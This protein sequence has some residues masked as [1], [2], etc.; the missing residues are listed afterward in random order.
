MNEIMT[1][2]H[3]LW[4]EFMTRLEGPEGCDFRE[5]ENENVTWKCNGGT[6]KSKARAILESMP[7]VDVTGSLEFF[8]ARG[9]H[10][11]CE[12]IFNVNS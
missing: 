10:C 4:G 2:K 3:D 8:E 7:G 12:I 5:D 11:D 9:G 1:P 6:D